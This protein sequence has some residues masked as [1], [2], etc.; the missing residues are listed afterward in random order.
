MK[1]C[2]QSYK[3]LILSI[4]LLYFHTFFAQQDSIAPQLNLQIDNLNFLKDNEY[5]NNIVEGY[6]LIGS[7][8]HPKLVYRAHPDLSLELGVFALQ[9]Y[10]QKS[11]Y[12]VIPTFTIHYKTEHNEMIF[13][14]LRNE[15]THNLIAPLLHE[16]TILD[17]RKVE[18]GTQNKWHTP[19]FDLETWINWETFIFKKD[20]LHEEMSVGLNSSWKLLQRKNW[21]INIPLQG[22]A[23]HHGGQYNIDNGKR[24]IYTTFNVAIGVEQTYFLNKNRVSWDSYFLQYKAFNQTEDLR[25]QAGIGLLNE[26]TYQTNHFKFKAGYWFG[27]QYYTPHGNPMFQSQSVRTNIHYQNG[28]EIPIYTYHTEPKR[29]LWLTEISFQKELIPKL[30]LKLALNTYYQNYYSNPRPTDNEFAINRQFDFSTTTMLSYSF[31]TLLK[32]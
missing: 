8:L 5:F 30:H 13:G 26:W 9:Y 6:T 23:Y 11:H 31:D 21:K 4:L 18:W 7:Q 20:T 32:K 22:M 17:Q 15:N 24:R 19:H 29:S 16:E 12:T 27:N 25:F 28:V 10:A 2:F 14:A 1:Y 3:I